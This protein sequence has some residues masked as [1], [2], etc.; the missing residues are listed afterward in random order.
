M[1]KFKLP[2]RLLSKPIKM[3]V[4]GAGGSGSQILTGLAQLH[5]TMI[6][7][8]HPY[9]L[10]VVV[11]D[12]DLVSASNIGRQMFLPPD[13]GRAKA[14]VMVNR[15][16]M[17]MGMNWKAKV[18]RVT[19][20][21]DMH[22]DFIIGC[23][24]SRAARAAILECAKRSRVAY[25]MD[26]GNKVHDGQMIFGEIPLPFDRAD[27][28]R[29]PTIAD[30]FPE[31]CDPSQDSDDDGPS[32]SLAEALEKQSLFV[33]RGVVLF[34]LNML[35]ELFR[36]GEISYHGVFVN[37]KTA[38]S[39]PLPIDPVAWEKR[40]GYTTGKPAEVPPASE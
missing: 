38:R 31:T 8:G 27:R 5:M 7:L 10:E 32:C 1:L 28:V 17:T 3:A 22:A 33:N 2:G 37:L 24:D 6:A 40:F 21:T 9:G 16:N 26:L 36:Y 11:Y 29:I 39:S 19:A 12:D 25:W 20:D 18:T 4:I 15:I 13:V 34:A 23:V 30:L 14:D 35:F